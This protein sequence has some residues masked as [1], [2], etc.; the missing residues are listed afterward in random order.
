V[1][2]TWNLYLEPEGRL[3]LFIKC[4]EEVFS[5]TQLPLMRVLGSSASGVWNSRKLNIYHCSC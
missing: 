1:L 2:G 3:P 5:E 4:L